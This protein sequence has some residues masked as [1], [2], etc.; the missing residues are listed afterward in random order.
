MHSG[1]DAR[2][3]SSSHRLLNIESAAS[4]VKLSNCQVEVK[5]DPETVRL[6]KHSP[7]SCFCDITQGRRVGSV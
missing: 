5:S 4:E 7:L 6:Q 2:D 1:S 3:G